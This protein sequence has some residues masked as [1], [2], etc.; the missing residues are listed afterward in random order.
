MQA[1]R[2]LIGLLR[3]EHHKGL[4]A[5]N[6]ISQSV[7]QGRD[8][9]DTVPWKT[10]ANLAQAEGL[11]AFVGRVSIEEGWAPAMPGEVLDYLS[12]RYLLNRIL[13]SECILE[14][15]AL[16]QKFIQ[17]G[18]L[19]IPIKGLALIQTLYRETGDRSFNDMDLLVK[20][21]CID[22]AASILVDSGY[23]QDPY[24]SRFGVEPARF[25]H[26]HLPPFRKGRITIELHYKMLPGDSEKFTRSFILSAQEN[27]GPDY[28]FFPEKYHHAV[29]LAAHLD[30]HASNG[31][32]QLR[33][34][35]DLACLL[36]NDESNWNKCSELSGEFNLDQ[37]FTK[38]RA[39]YRDIYWSSKYA[40]PFHVQKNQV[41]QRGHGWLRSLKSLPGWHLKILCIA[42]FLFP[43]VQYVRNHYPRWTGIRLPWWY[44]FRIY[45]GFRWLIS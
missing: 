8:I 19:A 37:A 2:F 13:T 25:L 42:D 6:E 32:N 18:I 26:H 1:S 22:L 4:T 35:R 5:L 27:R 33:L 29:F 36:G 14:F 39:V 10:L 24:R 30:K 31:Q 34:I 16:S 7:H 11:E 23:K 15:Q 38:V 45:R 28:G 17:C 20:P 12:E 43:S 9:A 44:V 40:F 21:D 41:S 3:S